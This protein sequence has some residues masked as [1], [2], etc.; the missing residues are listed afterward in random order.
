L[1]VGER[2]T[3][4]SR[5]SRKAAAAI[6]VCGALFAAA[7]CGGGEGVEEGATVRV[8]AGADVCAG[9]KDEL[10]RAGV[11]AG[12]V[13]ARVIC[14]GPVESG[15]RLDLAAAGA[16]A[17]RAIEDSSSVAYLE[18]P[19]PATRF[20]APIL[21]EA[22]LRLIAT[23]SGADGMD[24][25]LASLDDRSSDESPRESVWSGP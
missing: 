19:G 21:D 2:V 17:R 4:P 8:Y 13:R 10:A 20:T 11:R 22:A 24:T 18:A 5:I 23:G 16:N 25:V 14:A 15:G 12:S 6:A 3:R 7:G 9:A 1:S